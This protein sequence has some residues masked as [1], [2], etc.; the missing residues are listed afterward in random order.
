MTTFN[1]YLWQC[2]FFFSLNSRVHFYFRTLFL[3]MPKSIV[4]KRHFIFSLR[5]MFR[6]HQTLN[7]TRPGTKQC[8]AIKFAINWQMTTNK[9]YRKGRRKKL[10]EHFWRTELAKKRWLKYPPRHQNS[11]FSPGGIN[12]N[13]FVIQRGISHFRQRSIEQ[14]LVILGDLLMWNL[15]MSNCYLILIS[16]FP[17]NWA[18][19]KE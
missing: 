19:N 1:D 15:S 2:L 4:I 16:F 14:E 18:K 10:S 12:S 11:D 17:T 13:E 5:T 8:S 7:E 6:I 9:S 3:F